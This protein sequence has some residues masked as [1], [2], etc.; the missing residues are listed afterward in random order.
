MQWQLLRHSKDSHVSPLFQYSFR[1]LLLLLFVLPTVKS[2][3]C[4]LTSRKKLGR[5]SL[6]KILPLAFYCCCYCCC[7][8]A[9]DIDPRLSLSFRLWLWFRFWLWIALHFS[10]LR[11]RI[12]FGPLACALWLSSSPDKM[13]WNGLVVLPRPQTLIPEKQRDSK[14]TVIAMCLSVKI[15]SFRFHFTCVVL[16]FGLSYLY[17]SSFSFSFPSKFS[18]IV[19]LDVHSCC[20]NN[21]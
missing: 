15:T 20:C 8:L 3:A 13:G 10:R 2:C 6:I 1:L 19:A 17:S 21:F 18:S 12:S 14:T 16:L 7:V 11:T 4:T 5:P 9:F